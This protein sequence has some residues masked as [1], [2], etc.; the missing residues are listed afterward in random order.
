MLGRHIEKTVHSVSCAVCGSPRPPEDASSRPVLPCVNC[1]STTKHVGVTSVAFAGATASVRV[2]LTPSDQTA[3]WAHRWNEIS[4]RL[5][6]LQATRKDDLSAGSIYRAREELFDF[7]VLCYQL[8]D[9]VIA[10]GA[11]PKKQVEDKITEVPT[12]ALRSCPECPAQVKGAAD[13]G[14]S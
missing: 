11:V 3:A 6:E 14:S 8:K 7:Y 2:E 5:P 12:L 1:G 10:S 13:G 4:Q 9:H